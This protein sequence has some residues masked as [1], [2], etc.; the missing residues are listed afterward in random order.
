M[1]MFSQI[2]KSNFKVSK[3]EGAADTKGETETIVPT[4]HLPLSIPRKGS[5]ANHPPLSSSFDTSRFPRPNPF[6]VDN[7]Q[8]LRLRVS[9]SKRD[10]TMRAG[11]APRLSGMQ[12]QVLSL[13]RGFLRAARSK[14]PE[15]RSKI[16]SLVSAEFRKNS[17]F[18]DH[19]NILYIE[20]LFRRGKKQLEQLESPD[21]VS[22]SSLNVNTSE[23]EK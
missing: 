23:S 15:D 14:S 16:E 2:C 18:V 5:P 3:L 20:Y 10:N 8:Q 17:K 11:S 9:S 7:R 13:Y 19:K 22:L 1:L 6:A 4:G 21:T 12:R